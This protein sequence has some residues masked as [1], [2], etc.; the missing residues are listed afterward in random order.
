MRGPSRGGLFRQNDSAGVIV[1]FF[2]APDFKNPII[3]IG[4]MD[5]KPSLRF[6][7]R[8]LAGGGSLPPGFLDKA[9]HEIISSII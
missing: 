8:F 1:P 7:R 4:L 2:A 6:A 5:E 3:S 9:V